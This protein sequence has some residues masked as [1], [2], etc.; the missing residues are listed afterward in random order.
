MAST[1]YD[2]LITNGDERTGFMLDRVV[3]NFSGREKKT[4]PLQPGTPA[5][6]IYS[7]RDTE[8]PYPIEYKDWRAGAGQKLF[9]GEDARKNAFYVSSNMAVH[10]EGS[11]ELGPARWLFPYD[12]M[13][14]GAVGQ[15]SNLA[16]THSKIWA[17]FTMTTAVNGSQL[18]RLTHYAKAQSGAHALGTYT[19]TLLDFANTTGITLK[20]FAYCPTHG[21]IIRLDSAASSEYTVTRHIGESDADWAARNAIAPVVHTA[22]ETW[23]I[24]QTEDMAAAS[25]PSAPCVA[26]ASDGEKVYASFHTT[27]S[28]NG[29]VYCGTAAGAETDD[30]VV[31]STADSIIDLAY[32]NGVLYGVQVYYTGAVVTSMK[33]GWFSA[34]GVFTPIVGSAVLYPAA[35]HAALAVC[36]NFI[37]WITAAPG[38]SFIY[39]VQHST[40][41]TFEQVQKFPVDFTATCAYGGEGNVYV[42]GH[43][44]TG[45]LY[46]SDVTSHRKEGSVYA[47]IDGSNIRKLCRI[48]GPDDK[49]Y[50]VLALGPTNRFINILTKE[51]V[52]RYDLEVGGYHHYADVPTTTGT[53]AGQQITWSTESWE[54]ADGFFTDASHPADFLEQQ[55]D[56]TMQFIED[57]D[58]CWA[59]EINAK[60]AWDYFY[61]D[62][63]GFTSSFTVRAGF[64]HPQS[65]G[66]HIFASDASRIMGVWIR[67]AMVGGALD[68]CEIKFLK[69]NG[70]AFTPITL[71]PYD[72]DTVFD[73]W[74]TL[75]PVQGAQLWINGSLESTI[76]YT[77]LRPV[78]AGSSWKWRNA[79]H[80]GWGVGWPGYGTA[81]DS[82]TERMEFISLA[83]ATAGAYPYGYVG[84]T[85][86]TAS[87]I[88]TGLAGELYMPMP[89]SYLAF[90]TPR[91]QATSGS[92]ET[93][94]TTIETGTKNKRFSSVDVVHT[95][96]QTGQSLIITPI[97]DGVSLTPATISGPS[98]E[99]TPLVNSTVVINAQGRKIR[100]RVELL[101]TLPGRPTLQRLHVYNITAF[102]VMLPTNG[103]RTFVVNLQGGAKLRDGRTP[104]DVDT[105]LAIDRLYEMV[106]NTVSIESIHGNF[107]AYVAGV[108][109]VGGEVDFQT[110]DRE[111][112]RYQITLTEQAA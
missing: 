44:D 25:P 73:L 106:G 88:I 64:K 7:A 75:D 112:G 100:V 24:M 110:G 45:F 94:E 41:D 86:V 78:E 23:T 82:I 19:D 111:A 9:D 99:T 10:E 53:I 103:T 1:K 79:S 38:G 27:G 98:T 90:I 52:Y 60:N 36:D 18:K 70:T 57:W 109:G 51:A 62:E 74:M 39:R 26:L 20:C 6:S 22:G 108:S 104:Y 58:D 16:I 107:T 84:G 65:Q 40:E 77:D 30:W 96:L 3:D 76:A 71:G 5:N 8:P 66:G 92:L 59:V 67:G 49:N 93:S 97:V 43:T 29:D 15:I 42:G 61:K 17:A 68:H 33:V 87:K 12:T 105:Q 47:I 28:A 37:Y 89:S 2:L 48:T 14:A 69:W 4:P 50:S 35:T 56:V 72:A 81:T 31:F 80:I 32:C 46:A 63:A 13:A 11:F 95:Q 91:L 55:N 101:D 85:A 102:F 21:E 34:A 54:Y 83:W